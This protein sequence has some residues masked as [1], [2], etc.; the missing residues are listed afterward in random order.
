MKLRN[1]LFFIFSGKVEFDAEEDAH[2]VGDC[3]KVLTLVLIIVKTLFLI[4]G[5]LILY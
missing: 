5:K 2:V 1:D 3:V 4:I